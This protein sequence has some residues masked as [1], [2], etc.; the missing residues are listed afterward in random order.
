MDNILVHGATEEE[1]TVA[2]RRAPSGLDRSGVGLD[3]DRVEAVRQMS[4]PAGVQELRKIL[5]KLHGEQWKPVAC[6]SGRLT[7]TSTRCAQTEKKALPG[8]WAC[9]ESDR[10]LNGLQQFKLI[11]DRTPLVPLINSR[12]LDNVHM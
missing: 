5:G 9:E 4:P 7:E 1:K 2:W 12:S 3:P 8:V 10:Y 6:C 11:T